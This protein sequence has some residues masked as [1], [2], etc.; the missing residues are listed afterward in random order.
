MTLNLISE[1]CESTKPTKVTISLLRV[2]FWLFCQKYP[3]M[4][5][6]GQL[7][8]QIESPPM[9]NHFVETA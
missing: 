5:Y 4:Y 1:S 3:Q 6:Q 8:G 7:G 2:A 9:F